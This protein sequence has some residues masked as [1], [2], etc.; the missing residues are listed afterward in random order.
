MKKLLF[1]LL[2]SF[3]CIYLYAQNE[4][5]IIW[6]KTYGGNG[7]DAANSI[8]GTPDGGF[9]V[10]GYTSSKGYGNSDM[11]FLKLDKNGNKEWDKTYGGKSYDVAKSVINTSDGG[12]LIVGETKS[13]GKG[14]LDLCAIKIDSKGE[15]QWFKTFGGK[16]AEF[17]ASFVAVSPANEGYI[18]CGHTRSKGAGSYDYFLIKIDNSGSTVWEKTYGKSKEDFASAIIGTPDGGF[19]ISGN[20]RN[21][22]TNLF[23]AWLVKIDQKGNQVWERK[24]EG[25]DV[26][27]SIANAPDGGFI[28][29]GNTY[30]GGENSSWIVLRIDITGEII[31]EKVYGGTTIDYANNVISTYDGNYVVAGFTKSKGDANFDF[32]ILKIDKAG[33][34]A[35][36]KSFGGNQDDRALSILN[37]CEGKYV[38]AGFTKSEGAGMDDVSVI[39]FSGYLFD[40]KECLQGRLDSLQYLIN[41]KGEFESV[42][43]Y[44]NRLVMYEKMKADVIKQCQAEHDRMANEKIL[45]SY[46]YF[47]ATIDE[48][49]YYNVDKESF[50]ILLDKWYL[51]DMSIE[52][53]P[54]FKEHYQQVEVQGIK[55]LS[56]NLHDYE[57]IKMVINDPVIQKS[58]KFGKEVKTKD[59]ETL[60]AFN[61]STTTVEY[62]KITFNNSA[63]KG[64]PGSGYMT[65]EAAEDA[66]WEKELAEFKAQGAIEP[67]MKVKLVSY[68]DL[69]KSKGEF[70][71]T[72]EYKYRLADYKDLKETALDEC[73][74]EQRIANEEKIRQSYTYAS[75]DIEEIGSYNSDSEEFKLKV[76]GKW[77]VANI[78]VK[79]AQTFREH[80]KQIEVKGVKKLT[81]DLKGYEYFNLQV[82][83]SAEGKKYPIGKQVK[84]K[85]DEFLQEF[86]QQE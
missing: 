70:E 39:K 44:K 47:S 58:Y 72:K 14:S 43:D 46:E 8:I 9:A 7:G 80:W 52:E 24:Y 37:V 4:A 20:S 66:L 40:L 71:T 75:F 2:F 15:R 65:P 57:L 5:E 21:I 51:L 63:L 35:W 36:K 16:N 86:Y 81:N 13:K 84:P 79:E 19:L 69:L 77:Y 82:Y 78:G 30:K 68:K 42:A 53:A 85:D 56:K 18:V 12:Y 50:K 60:K 25:Y 6:Q 73:L 17:S 59:D 49:S 67:C 74:E 64:N 54:T 11:W 38:V 10:V 55:R 45:A 41:P 83:H 34:K 48:L 61:D 28:A 22:E 31:W 32:W 26:I 62:K 33:N 29:A 3:A 76:N 1:T 23:E 27:N